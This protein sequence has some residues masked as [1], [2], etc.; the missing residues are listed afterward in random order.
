MR[1]RGRSPLDELSRSGNHLDEV[2]P[3]TLPTDL[4]D[5]L[6]LNL[7]VR[8]GPTAD[9]LSQRRLNV[10]WLGQLLLRHRDALQ[11][12]RDGVGQVDGVG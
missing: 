12:G 9:Q 11:S 8:F 5:P 1:K 10:Q 4:Q 6:E 3:H 7:S 2:L